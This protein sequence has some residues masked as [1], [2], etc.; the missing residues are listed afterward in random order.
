LVE[1]GIVDGD[2][3]LS[4]HAGDQLLVVLVEA[5]SSGCPRN[6]PPMTSPERD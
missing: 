6:R 1:P 2:G 4:C 5:S 3:R